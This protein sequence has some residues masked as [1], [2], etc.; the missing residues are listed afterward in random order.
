SVTI[1]SVAV[2]ACVLLVEASLDAMRMS[3]AFWLLCLVYLLGSRLAVRWLLQSRDAAGDRVVVYGA[4]DAGAHL[5]SALRGRG[6]FLPVAFVDD[7]PTL[8][9]AVIRG[10]E[11]H[12]PHMIG[13]F[14]EEFGVS[15][16]LLALPS[17]SRRRR[18][19]I[20]NQLEQLPV[21]VQTMP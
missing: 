6:A 13:T 4:G 21:H 19:E 18:L 20:I 7:N 14:I 5:V 2:L 16:V 3:L 17:V 8:R 10:L 11:V 15:R 12:A 1:A 9:G